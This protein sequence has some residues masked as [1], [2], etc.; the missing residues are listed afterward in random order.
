MAATL[1]HAYFRNSKAPESVSSRQ[2]KT[3]KTNRKPRLVKKPK[4]HKSASLN[5]NQS[6]DVKA[7]VE[8]RSSS[9]TRELCA[10]VDSGCMEHALHL[11]ERMNRCD[12]YVWNVMIRGFTSNWLFREAI[13]FYCR[14]GSEGVLGDNF[15]Y[16]FVIKA[17]TGLLSFMEGQKV[18]GK[19]FKIGLDLDVY[20][21]N[22]LIVM[23]AKMGC[24][25]FAERVFGE[26]PVR[27][28]VS[29]CWGLL[30]LID[31][32]LGNA[33]TWNDA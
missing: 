28:L 30:E 2:V 26:M 25:E 33:G 17:C 13:D 14:M 20:V 21:C 22:S 8:P 9:L 4:V 5:R 24:V 1:A 7:L 12:P 6:D 31:V 15:T 18:H 10:F 11:F 27:D 16:P 19:L 3:M 23:Y 29:Y 32:F